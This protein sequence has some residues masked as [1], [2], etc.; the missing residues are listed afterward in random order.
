MDK[1]WW[2]SEEVG[3][4]RNTHPVLVKPPGVGCDPSLMQIWEM[5]ALGFDME[6]VAV[7]EKT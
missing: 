3:W 4:V 1:L 2:A 7:Q 5:I 6:K